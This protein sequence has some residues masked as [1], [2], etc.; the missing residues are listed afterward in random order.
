MEAESLT[1][2]LAL[3]GA[4]TGTIGTI[5]GIANLV[6][7][8]KQHKKDQPRLLCSSNFSFGH[9]AGSPHPKHKLTLRS[10]GKR[11]VTIDYV[12]YFI[13]PKSFW[14]SLFR[15]RAWHQNR[16]KYDYHPKSTMQITEGK[17]E[18]IGISMPDGLSILDI[19]KVEVHDQSGTAWKV[20]WPSSKRLEIEVHNEKLHESEESN[21]E[22]L[23]KVSGY[24]AAGKYHIY[25][26]WNPTPKNKSSTKGRFFHFN[27]ENEYQAK[28]RDI[29]DVQQPKILACELD[30]IV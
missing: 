6:L 1:Q 9:F 2:T 14:Q 18:E 30:E 26:H 17:K 7:R 24:T 23:C 12:R 15:H 20:K 28:L 25:T 22:R 29:L 3:W 10:I 4:V 16:W 21:T 11:P 19:V 8:F 5:A 27:N 13:K